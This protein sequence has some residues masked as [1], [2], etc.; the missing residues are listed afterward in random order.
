MNA[1]HLGVSELGR[2]LFG[3]M[4]D[5]GLHLRPDLH[6]R[7]LRLPAPPDGLEFHLKCANA[8]GHHCCEEHRLI[9][10]PLVLVVDMLVPEIVDDEECHN[11]QMWQS[12]QP[13]D[14]YW[15]TDVTIIHDWVPYP[16]RPHRS[17]NVIEAACLFAQHPYLGSVQSHDEPRSWGHGRIQVYRS[18]KEGYIVASRFGIPAYNHHTAFTTGLFGLNA[19]SI[20]PKRVHKDKLKEPE[21]QPPPAA[22][23][24]TGTSPP[25]EQPPREQPMDFTGSI[26][27]D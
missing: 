21:Q 3:R 1:L 14:P 12:Y 16:D 5:A 25:P 11:L 18:P 23:T 24:T 26:P 19:P 27:P 2:L 7:N 8:N 10:I 6:E 9:R 13:F 22:E 15:L 20:S 4:K 17:L